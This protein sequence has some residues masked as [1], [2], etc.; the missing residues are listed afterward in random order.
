MLRKPNPEGSKYLTIRRDMLIMGGIKYR[1]IKGMKD[2][3]ADIRGHTV[4]DLKGD[5]ATKLGS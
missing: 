2:H 5:L 4:Q 1:L 3:D